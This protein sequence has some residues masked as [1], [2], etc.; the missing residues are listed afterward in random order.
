MGGEEWGGSVEWGGKERRAGT[1]GKERVTF[2]SCTWP[3]YESWK[4][5]LKVGITLFLLPYTLPS[6]HSK[7]VSL[8]FLSPQ[9]DFLEYATGE[10]HSIVVVVVAAVVVV[11]SIVGEC[12]RGERFVV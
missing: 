11:W 5:E 9:L 6:S 3:T 4:V 12:G 10:F 2:P 8:E 1:S 7:V